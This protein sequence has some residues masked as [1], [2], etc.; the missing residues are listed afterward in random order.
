[1]LKDVLVKTP[2]WRSRISMLT[3]AALAACSSGAAGAAQ[4]IETGTPAATAEAAAGGDWGSLVPGLTGGSTA[5]TNTGIVGDTY[6]L[7]SSGVEVVVG[8]GVVVS[9]SETGTVE[10]QI[11]VETDG[12]LGAV[13]VLESFGQPAGTLERYVSGFA[14]TMDDV[15]EI[16][17]QS[18][19]DLATG[20]YRVETSGLTLYMFI[21]VDSQSVS[22]YMV[23]EVAIAGADDME[24][25]IIQIRENVNINGVPAFANVNESDVVDVIRTDEG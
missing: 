13:A 7:P 22:G 19:A 8:D 12:G 5:A 17:T 24:A 4:Y 3:L 2:N 23:I 11:I 1:M 15:V 18:S 6:V 25:S 14:E 20:I 21:S 10:D 16:D 9:E